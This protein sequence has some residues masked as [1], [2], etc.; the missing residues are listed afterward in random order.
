LFA[1]ITVA[2]VAIPQAMAYALIF[3]MPVQYGLYTAI[4]MTVVGALL[5]PSR[6]LINGP[7]N[8]IS[9]AMLSALA[10]V[11]DESRIAAAIAMAFLIGLIQ[12][13]ITV[14]RIGDLSRF[15]SHSVIIG[16][17]LGASLL[18][19]LDQLKNVLGLTAL[20]D[21]ED[22]FLVRFWKTMSGG[23]P[24][25]VPTLGVAAGTIVV[26]LAGRWINRRMGWGIPALLTGI[27]AAAIAVQGF[28][29]AESGV[30]LVAE[31]PP[32]L[33]SFQIPELSWSWIQQFAGSAS[34]VALLGLL[35][36]VAM[37][38]SLASK[39][40]QKLDMNQMCLSEGVANL[41][42][43]FFQCFPG[44]GSLT[45][46][47]INYQAGATSQWAGVICAA[48]VALTVV[49]F[50][51]LAQFIPRAAL[52]GVLMLTAVGM[53]DRILLAYHVRATRFDA[54]IL[55]ATAVSAIAV[56]VEF[57]ILIGVFLSFVFYVPRAA[58]INMSELIV[59]NDRVVRE[60]LAGE[61]CTE[62]FRIYD[63]EGEL[64]FGS[65][66]TFTELLE[67]IDRESAAAEIILL[68][69]KRVRNADAVCLHAFDEFLRRMERAGK[70][71]LLSGVRGGL[72]ATLNRLG[73]IERLG[74]D[75]IFREVP[76][77]WSSTLDAVRWAHEHLGL[78]TRQ[79]AGSDE[80]E[81][82][83]ADGWHFVV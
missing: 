37:A 48:M 56:S 61:A 38:K 25:H 33:P 19:V 10:T 36:A 78:T 65:A 20:G 26:V 81:S 70:T 75:R 72:Y 16:F 23:G 52:A 73:I 18:L 2:T 29:L 32:N 43:S 55:T 63:F 14:F 50:A 60:R 68:R 6:H 15:V 57:C 42:G 67:Q 47:Y 69:L 35:E 71:I 41:A 4:V 28:G 8:A 21:H 51:P 79:P 44:S 12:I 3:G 27:I 58:R 83:T 77:I 1:G 80:P 53:T 59:T 11:P 66:P 54:L 22:H 39:T 9:I 31:I 40:G 62:R 5:T 7:T 17:T 49:A 46:S 13:G 64:F 34:A 74:S 24:I 45:R 82:H 30:K 76:Q